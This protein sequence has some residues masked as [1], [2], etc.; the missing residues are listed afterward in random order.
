M[1][2]APGTQ[3]TTTAATRGAAAVPVL[4]GAVAGLAWATALR[5][6]MVQVAGPESTVEWGGTV[7]GILLPGLVA[8]A[9]LGAAEHLRR[10]G[11]PHRG[12][13]A[14]APLAFV[15]ATPGVLVSVITDGG[16]GGGAIALPLLGIAGGWA[17][18]GRGPVAARVVAGALPVAGAVGWAVG[19]PA[20]A[21]ALAVTTARGAWVAV[22]FAALLAVQSLG[23]AVPHRPAG[24]PLVP[25]ARAAA[26]IGA[27]CG[28]AWAAGLRS[29]MVEIAEPGPSHVSWAGT[30]AGI[31]L[32][33]LVVGVLLGRAPHRRGPGR[34]R[35]GRGR[36]AVGVVAG[37]AAAGVVIAGGLGGGALAVVLC[38]LA[39]GYALAGSG[40]PAFRVAAGLL[41][42]AVV[43][44]W[45]VA[46]AVV[47][48]D[49]P[50][51]GARGAWVAALLASHLAVL[52]LACAL[53]YRRH[54]APLA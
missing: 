51:T 29:L 27:V 43:V 8:G 6:L 10:T 24:G 30:F 31:L 22:L 2:S 19:A 34:L 1:S 47:G 44:A 50:G 52:A 16:I 49:E 42:V 28:L 4:I 48:L 32:P 14:L 54:R 41:P 12:W 23:C 18:G 25:S 33:G 38:G 15:V 11:H 26:V 40:R 36:S 3:A 7:G 45:S 5:G 21:P 20:I 46:T 13:L 53:P 35:G 39:G 9:L 37:A 17:L